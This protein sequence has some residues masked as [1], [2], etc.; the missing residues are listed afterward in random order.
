MAAALKIQCLCGQAFTAKALDGSVRTHCPV[1]KR[2]V[3]VE[4]VEALL[5]AEL[6]PETPNSF[7]VRPFECYCLY[8]P[9]PLTPPAKAQIASEPMVGLWRDGD[10]IVVHRSQHRFPN[11]CVMTNE[12]L[13]GLPGTIELDYLPNRWTWSLLGKSVGR[14]VG[15]ALYGEVIVLRAGISPGWQTQ[16]W[17][18][19][20]I[21][22]LMIWVGAFLAI[23]AALASMLAK[24]PDAHPAAAAVSSLLMLAFGGLFLGGMI[25]L[26][27]SLPLR[28]WMV[29]GDYVWLRGASSDFAAILPQ[30]PRP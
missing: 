23:P 5:V 27:L 15:R 26:V 12:P 29:R 8:N 18:R 20:A 16:N 11:R 21:G 2:P 13:D 3:P 6:V 9:L 7:E 4:P 1:C 30:W 14:A 28:V 22:T 19:R 10:M 24:N 25:V 17:V